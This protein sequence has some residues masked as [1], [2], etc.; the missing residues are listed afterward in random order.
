MVFR[1]F[2]AAIINVMHRSRLSI[3]AP[4]PSSWPA[5]S[6]CPAWSPS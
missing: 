2:L 6:R 3:A 5:P 4:A 1:L